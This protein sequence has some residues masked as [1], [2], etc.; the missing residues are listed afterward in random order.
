MTDEIFSKARPFASLLFAVRV[1]DA[2]AASVL[3]K[4]N[5]AVSDTGVT[6]YV[7]EVP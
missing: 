1:T 2:L 4:R 3:L 6:A 5:C 7:V